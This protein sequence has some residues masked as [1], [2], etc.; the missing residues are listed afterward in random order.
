MMHAPTS[1]LA[2]DLQVSVSKLASGGD[3][4]AELA[5][6]T[7]AAAGAGA[8]QAAAAAGA[9]EAATKARGKLVSG[10]HHNALVE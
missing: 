9:A 4:D 2:H 7:A 5:A 6:A 10:V 8:T 3:D 1:R